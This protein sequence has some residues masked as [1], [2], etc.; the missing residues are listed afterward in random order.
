MNF[1]QRIY[2]KTVRDKLNRPF[3][4]LGIKKRDVFLVSTPYAVK[5]FLKML[6]LLGGLRKL[7]SVILLVPETFMSFIKMFKSNTFHV[8]YWKKIPQIMTRE[9]DLLKKELKNY[10]CNWLIELNE[11]AN[12]SL[13]G[14]IDVPKRIAFYGQKNF[15]YYNILVKNGIDSLINFLQ[16]QLVEPHTL[17][18]FNKLELKALSKSLPGNHPLLFFNTIRDSESEKIE[19]SGS[20]VVYNKAAEGIEEACKKIFLCD[21]YLGPDDEFCEIARIFKKEIITK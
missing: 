6:P 10:Q 12:L 20:I 18:K 11:N 14:L 4:P 3:K 8:I 16:I 1:I 21:A 15:P 7:G 17:F 19:W 2:L 13:P 9:Y 5:D